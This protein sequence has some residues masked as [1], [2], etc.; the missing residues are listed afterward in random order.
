MSNNVTENIKPKKAM[1]INQDKLARERTNLSITR[2][3][4]AYMNTRMSLTRTHMSYISTI[5]SLVVASA[6]I[7]K[8]LPAIGVSVKF[9]SLLAVLLLVCAGYFAYKDAVEYP[10]MKKHLQEMEDKTEELKA[11]TAEEII[12]IEN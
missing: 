11:K 8:G 3:E 2:T 6:T 5:V 9:A 7:Y 10:E 4:L 1:A 12:D